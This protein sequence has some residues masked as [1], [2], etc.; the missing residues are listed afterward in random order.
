MLLKAHGYEQNLVDASSVIFYSY[1]DLRDAIA[2]QERKTGEKATLELADCYVD[3]HEKWMQVA[4]YTM[5]YESFLHEKESFIPD[6]VKILNA[7][8][9]ISCDSNSKP[10]NPENILGEIEQLNYAADGEKTNLYH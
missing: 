1:R 10:A 5:K 2:S 9:I 7:K 3:A 8:Q 4:D 6:I